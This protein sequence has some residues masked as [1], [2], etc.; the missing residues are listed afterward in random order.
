[1]H[2]KRRPRADFF[3]AG[4]S[5]NG[6][7][8]K[9]VAENGLEDF[10]HMIAK[11]RPPLMRTSSKNYDRKD[12]QI[13]RIQSILTSFFVLVYCAR[14]IKLIL[15]ITYLRGVIGGFLL[16]CLFRRFSPSEGR[17]Q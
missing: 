11:T 12:L 1:M 14:I 2:I 9:V 10:R 16:R 13:L 4:G 8:G 6:C 7:T 3:M 17:N 15:H 5:G